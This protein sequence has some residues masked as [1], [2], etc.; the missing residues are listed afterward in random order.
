MSSK[1]EF[2][3]VKSLSKTLCNRL[4]PVGKTLEWMEKEGWITEAEEKDAAQK[5]A[6]EIMDDFYRNEIQESLKESKIEW[7]DLFDM[8]RAVRKDSQK[9][10]E[11]LEVKNNK[12]LVIS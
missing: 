12:L 7:Q 8:I 10:K 5:E 9:E 1:K 11:L 6:K 3:G 2:I 4:I